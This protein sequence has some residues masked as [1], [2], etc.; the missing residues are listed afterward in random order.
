M[1]QDAKSKAVI[2]RVRVYS[3]HVQSSAVLTREQ[4]GA[5]SGNSNLL[6]MI[7]A[8]PAAGLTQER[9][10]LVARQQHAAASDEQQR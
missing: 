5:T 10:L 9:P 6:A 3:I 1:L 4:Y 2:I 7:E 8:T